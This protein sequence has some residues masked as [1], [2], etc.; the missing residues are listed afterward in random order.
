M[1]DAGVKRAAKH[2]PKGMTFIDELTWRA[3]R[4]QRGGNLKLKVIQGVAWRRRVRVR[5]IRL[6]HAVR[7]V[8]GGGLNE[9]GGPQIRRNGQQ[10]LTGFLATKRRQ[11]RHTSRKGFMEGSRFAHYPDHQTRSDR[12]L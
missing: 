8:L 6:Q 3:I 1:W 7:Q 2:L 4:R 11:Q 12:R 10:S 9:V 5:T